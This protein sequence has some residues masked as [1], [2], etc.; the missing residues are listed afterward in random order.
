MDSGKELIGRWEVATW[1]AHGNIPPADGLWPE[2]PWGE[3][4]SLLL[5]EL[6]CWWCCGVGDVVLL[7]VLGVFM[8]FVVLV[9]VGLVVLMMLVVLVVL[10]GWWYL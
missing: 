6:W 10:V 1:K 8:V 9:L 4:W 7:V 2:Q 5:V 3:W